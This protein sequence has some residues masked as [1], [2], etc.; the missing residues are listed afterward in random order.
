MDVTSGDLVIVLR[1][2]L[3]ERNIVDTAHPARMLVVGTVRSRE[4]GQIEGGNSGQR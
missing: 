4:G 1:W 3:Q 2:V